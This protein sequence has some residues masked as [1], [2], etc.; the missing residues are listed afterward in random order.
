MSPIILRTPLRHCIFLRSTHVSTRRLFS[1]SPAKKAARPWKS[2]IIRWGIAIG[3]IYY[4]NTSSLFAEIPEISILKP[5]FTK[6][7]TLEKSSYQLNST[8]KDERNIGLTQ[9]VSEQSPKQATRT[10]VSGFQEPESE[11]KEAEIIEGE[12]ASGQAEAF[13][14]ETGEINWDCPCLGGMAQGPCGEEFKAAF[15]CFVYSK[16]EPKGVECIEKFKN[17]QECFRQHPD[18][19]GAELG[20]DEAEEVNSEGKDES[21]ENSG[22]TDTSLEQKPYDSNQGPES[23]LE[24]TKSASKNASDEVKISKSGE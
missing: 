24:T 13:N 14:P 10:S 22:Q 9:T 8:P 5:A 2:T 18:I 17:M 4:Y 19:Y 11:D 12:N 3:G 20:D 15:S 1:E 6:E 23:P 21:L 16:E 7:S